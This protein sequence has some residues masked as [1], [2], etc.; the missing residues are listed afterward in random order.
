MCPW[1]QQL[2]ATCFEKWRIKSLKF[3]GWNILATRMLQVSWATFPIRHMAAVL[4]E[5]EGLEVFF[6]GTFWTDCWWENFGFVFAKQCIAACLLSE[7]TT[8]PFLLAPCGSGGG[9]SWWN[10]WSIGCCQEPKGTEVLCSSFRWS[11]WMKR[12]VPASLHCSQSEE[13]TVAASDVQRDEPHF[14]L[15]N[16][17][18]QRISFQYGC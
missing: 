18:N 11:I 6:P 16:Q 17:A 3:W 15:P 14:S 4:R 1:W 5:G 2:F 10:N 9:G 12:T 7:A 8:F 13:M